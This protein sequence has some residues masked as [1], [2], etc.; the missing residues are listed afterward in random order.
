[1][2]PFNLRVSPMKVLVKI[3]RLLHPAAADYR[4]FR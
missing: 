2:D 1:M 4:K 3:F